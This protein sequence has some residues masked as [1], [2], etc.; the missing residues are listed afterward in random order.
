MPRRPDPERLAVWRLL[1]ET[2]A[3]VVD[4]LG[5]ELEAECDL[6]LTWY[7]VLLQLSDAPGGRLRMRDLAAAVLLSRSGLTRLVDRMQAAGLVCREAHPSDG[8]GAN[9][10]LTPAGRTALRRAAPVHLR[11]IED[12]FARH[13]ADQ[14]VPVL[15]AALD[16]VVTAERDHPTAPGPDPASP[17]SE[18]DPRR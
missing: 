2:H 7:D 6:P 3:A 13:L 8:R 4:R 12:H 15:R 10:V 16:R 5:R 9:A 17:P 11:G 14:D 18:P 1:L